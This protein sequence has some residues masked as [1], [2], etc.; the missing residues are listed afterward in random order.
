MHYF[1]MHQAWQSGHLLVLEPARGTRAG[2]RRV[3]GLRGALFSRMKPQDSVEHAWLGKGYHM[4]ACILVFLL[5]VPCQVRAPGFT[6]LVT[7]FANREY[8]DMCHV[9]G[10]V[11]F[12]RKREYDHGNI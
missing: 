5:H 12:L 4:H 9:C 1:R 7:L 2:E 11:F 10:N 3:L 6:H 8:H